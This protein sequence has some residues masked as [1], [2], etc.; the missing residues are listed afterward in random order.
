M[1]IAPNNIPQLRENNYNYAIDW[2]KQAGGQD[3]AIT[4]DIPLLQPKQGG[5]IRWGS[6]TRN[7][8]IY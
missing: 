4:A 3:N 5:R 7:I 1:R 6:N 2:L 8:N